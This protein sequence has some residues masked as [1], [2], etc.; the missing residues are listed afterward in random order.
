MVGWSYNKNVKIRDFILGN[1]VLRKI[2]G[3][4]RDP[5]W[6]KLGP[7]WEGLYKVVLIARKGAYGLE[8]LDGNIVPRLMECKQ[9]EKK[10]YY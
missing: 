4:I 7:T 5:S 10:Y 9:L 6:G 1:L 8:D 3:N 2:T